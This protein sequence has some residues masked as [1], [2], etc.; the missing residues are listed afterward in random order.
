MGQQ[1][2]DLIPAGAAQAGLAQSTLGAS[3]RNGHDWEV[4]GKGRADG[5]GSACTEVVPGKKHGSV[6]CVSSGCGQNSLRA[7]LSVALLPRSLQPVPNTAPALASAGDGPGL[8]G[9]APGNQGKMVK[10]CHPWSP[11]CPKQPVA[12]PVPALVQE[13]ALPFLFLLC[14]V[15]FPVNPRFLGNCIP[16]CE[17]QFKTI[18]HVADCFMERKRLL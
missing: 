10:G 13:G 17:S 6:T 12:Q 1:R 16:R 15:P 3:L 5:K 14:L 7:T 2:R 4:L 18:T 9:T 11:L 8:S